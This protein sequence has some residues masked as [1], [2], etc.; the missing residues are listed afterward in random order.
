M[1]FR[2]SG[3]GFEGG[4]GLL[5]LERPAP[6]FPRSRETLAEISGDQPSD[7]SRC[8]KSSGLRP[9]TNNDTATP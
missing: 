1:A 2:A 3:D 9:A 7:W 6:N 8:S 4:S 5:C